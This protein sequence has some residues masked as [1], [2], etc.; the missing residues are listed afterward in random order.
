MR[1]HYDF[2]KGKRGALV[3]TA[4]E[5]ITIHLYPDVIQWF[6]DSVEDGGN[7]QNLINEVLHQH[8]QK[9]RKPLK[10]LS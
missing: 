4:Q 10:I 9:H 7:Y 8:M 6:K 5:R 3:K 2:S 1:D